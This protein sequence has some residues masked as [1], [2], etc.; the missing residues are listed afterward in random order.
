MCIDEAIERAEENDWKHFYARS[1]IMASIHNFSEAIND[2][3]IAINL[4]PSEADAYFI[5]SSCFQI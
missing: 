3:T 2:S 5:R 4:K 1:L